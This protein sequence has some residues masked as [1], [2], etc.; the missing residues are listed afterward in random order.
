MLPE[1]GQILLLLALLAALLQ[2]SLPLIGAQRGIASWMQ[3]A[4]PAA[5]A[6]LLL[7]A[8]AFALRT[9]ALVPPA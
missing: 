3:V 9:A 2:A 6:Q 7:V 1:L 4:R 5:L 8:A